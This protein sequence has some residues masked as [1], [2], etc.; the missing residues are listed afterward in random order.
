MEKYPKKIVIFYCC[1]WVVFSEGVNIWHC[2]RI[3]Y[4]VL[5]NKAIPNCTT[6]FMRRERRVE[7]E[8]VRTS[9]DLFHRN[10]YSR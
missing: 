1:F 5:K 8:A 10:P 9:S 3:G 6:L 4:I 7:L 2:V